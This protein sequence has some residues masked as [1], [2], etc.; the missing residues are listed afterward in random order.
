MRT[1]ILSRVNRAFP[2][3]LRKR[4]A[5]FALVTSLTVAACGEAPKPTPQLTAIPTPI[6]TEMP[7]PQPTGT[8]T[9]APTESPMPESTSTATVTPE[10]TK[11]PTPTKKPATDGGTLPKSA[12]VIWNGSRSSKV[13]YLTFDDCWQ[14]ISPVVETAQKMGAKITFFCIGQAIRN[15]SGQSAAIKEGLSDGDEFENHTD[16]HPDLAGV[17]NVSYI[18][19][20]LLNQW[21]SLR[22][23]AGD[24]NLPELALRPPYGDGYGNPYVWE[25]VKDVGLKAIVMWSVDSGGTSDA[26]DTSSARIKTL[27]NTV[28]SG[29]LDKNG[30]LIGGRIILQHVRPADEAA[31][32]Q[33][34]EEI[35]AKGGSFG[36]ISDLITGSTALFY[37]TQQPNQPRSN[38]VFAKKEDGE[39]YADFDAKAA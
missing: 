19:N 24:P 9:L 33:L 39:E 28:N 2:E 12:D 36:L 21:A 17:T 7:T 29:L 25:A 3:P 31:L 22:K 10:P 38:E 5:A 4:T 27:I 34:I 1:E 30:N 18:K 20:Q 37:L 32:A 14:N 26:Y 6:V 8:P 23:A 15:V 11:T 35:K 13:E 16:T